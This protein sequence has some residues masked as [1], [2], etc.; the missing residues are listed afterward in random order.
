L[1]RKRKN[2][3]EGDYYLPI[4][5]VESED[6]KILLQKTGNEGFGEKIIGV[7]EAVDGRTHEEHETAAHRQDRLR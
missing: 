2:L 6:T 5:R 7:V 4:K 1:G 3:A